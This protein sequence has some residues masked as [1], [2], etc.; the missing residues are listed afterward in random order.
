MTTDDPEA[1][2]IID[3]RS[4]YQVPSKR[5]ARF[6]DSERQSPLEAFQ[7]LR[8]LQQFSLIQ[9]DSTMIFLLRR[10]VTPRTALQAASEMAAQIVQPVLDKIDP[11]DLGAFQLDASLSIEY[12]RRICEPDDPSK[13][14]QRA[15]NYR[16]L[17]EKYPAHEFIIDA[18]EATSLGLSVCEPD[19]TV[20]GLFDSLREH[21]DGIQHYVGMISERE[22]TP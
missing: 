18:K 16:A 4:N 2:L 17:V 12:C 10:H 20:N 15:A 19:E 13:K 7:A 14:T 11:Y 21:L 9:L 3:G 1:L 8:A 22:E 6:F 5:S